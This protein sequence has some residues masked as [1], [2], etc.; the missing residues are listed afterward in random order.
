MQTSEKIEELAKA[1]SKAQALIHNA[2]KD[3]LNPHFKSKYADLASIW[4][5]CRKPL[6]TNGLSIVQ[7]LSNRDGQVVCTTMLLHESGQFIKDEFGMTPSQ[8]TPQAAGSCATYLRRY[9]LASTVGVAPDDDDG[10]DASGKSQPRQLV[11]TAFG[12]T[13]PNEHIQAIVAH[14]QGEAA[15]R[16]AVDAKPTA[17]SGV[18]PFSADNPKHTKFI[19]AFLLKRGGITHYNQLIAAMKGKAS[20][21]AVVEAEWAKINPEAPDQIPE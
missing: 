13:P 18:L 11:S 2:H 5:A 17:D 14:V 20:L 10:N 3:S 21:P 4:D 15:K 6:T 7:T 19:E 1:L 12:V 9:C 16:A 8:N